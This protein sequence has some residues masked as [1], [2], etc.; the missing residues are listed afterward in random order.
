MNL[1]FSGG[2]S[3]WIPEIQLDRPYVMLSYWVNVNR[4]TG[5]PDS[6]FVKLVK[7]RSKKKK[8]GKKK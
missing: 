4:K 8:G 3:P 7:V 1:F 2:G 6:R 5:K